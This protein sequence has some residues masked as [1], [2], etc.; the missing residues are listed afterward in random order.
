MTRALPVAG[1]KA[2]SDAT[3]GRGRG[4]GS[5]ADRIAH[6]APAAMKWLW[7]AGLAVALVLPLL[8]LF[9]QAWFDEAGR[10]ALPARVA[11]LVANPNF[12]PLLGRSVAVSL[13]VAALVVPLAFGF[14][15]ALQRSRIAFK[16]LWRGIALLPLFAPSLLPG[17][18][19]VY[20]FGN[21][22]VFK[23]AFGAGGIY[24]F[25]GI[26]LGEAFYT[27]PH[28]LMVLMAAL[29]LADARLYEAARA[30]GASAW[31]TFLTV[32]L[33]GARH[34]LF[35]AACLVFTLVVTDFGVPK[36]VG[37]G[38]P[39]LALEAY[40]AVVG[41]Q[42]FARG[43]LIGML[44]L[45]P[46]LLTFG[47]DI[48]MQRRQRAQMS[49]RAQVYVP[50]RDGLRDTCC[51][52]V[53]MVTGAALLTMLAAA[54]GASL[55]K[56]WPYNLQ[57]TLAHYDF[58][59]MDGGGWLAYRNSLRLA[60]LSALA[61]TLAIFFGA[62]LTERTRGPAW[63]HGVLRAGFVLPMAVPGLVLGLGYVF[64]FNAPSNPLHALYGTMTLLVICNVAHFYTTG[65]LTA[66]AALRQLDAEFEAA[67]LSLGVAP[68]VTC[69]RVTVPICLPALIDI[70][71]YLFVS[72]MT[73]VSAVIFLYSPDTVLA[74]ISVLN[75][76]DA[77][78]TAPAAAMSTLILLTS[79]LACLLLMG[80]ARGWLRRTQAWRAPA[81]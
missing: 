66:A 31:R 53:V 48:A 14:A 20:L 15:Y 47:V 37:G 61:G 75:M 72:A 63:L 49:S 39:V 44:L 1:A 65:H 12:L 54:V 50:G 74:A 67:A 3:V 41:Q 18:A 27:F 51:T 32:T 60:A 9:G 6:A 33:P 55:V 8:A 42:Q 35:G 73:T 11:E 59:N 16:P 17:I 28:A 30:M 77:G 79:A 62:W 4:A 69:W 29:S 70:F 45:L 38:Y 46:A 22:G 43:A 76:D 34:G 24:G 25:W 71:R 68:L 81:P 10:W 7:L 78:D 26:V 57:L 2:D 21:Q 23:G 19:L 40:K 13:T 80:A 52:L 5:A 58:D 56:L 36:V 64:F